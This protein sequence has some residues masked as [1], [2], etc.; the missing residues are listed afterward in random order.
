MRRLLVV[1]LLAAP[2]ASATDV[3]LD[4]DVAAGMFQRDVD[5][6][7]AMIQAFHSPSLTIRGVSAVFGNSPLDKGLPIARE[8]AE[9]FGPAGLYVQPGA[10]GADE[11]GRSSEAVRAMAVSLRAKP[12]T[13]LALGP[14]TNVGTLVMHHPELHDRIER[15]VMVAARRPDQHFTYPDNQGMPFPDFNFEQ[16]PAAMKRLLATDIRLEFAPW[17]VSS[18][19]WLYPEDLG[20][21]R[22]AGGSGE[23]IAEKSQSWIAMWRE[24][25]GLPGFNPFDTLAVAWVTHPQLIESMEAGIWIELGPDDRV[26]EPINGDRPLKPYLLVDSDPNKSRRVVYT[27]KPAGEMKTILVERLA[28]LAGE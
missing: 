9:K 25:L 24:R 28:G 22:E 1:L 20:T 17:E 26:R 5:D 27:Y 15:I 21:L 11:L 7:L 13:I 16:D 3:W 19:V 10:A 2:T 14:V 8:V 18:H 23:W 12:M 6:A 4:V